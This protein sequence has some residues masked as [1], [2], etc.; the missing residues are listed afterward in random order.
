MYLYR[1]HTERK[2]CVN[3]HQNF[4]IGDMNSPRGAGECCHEVEQN[5]NKIL[6]HKFFKNIMKQLQLWRKITRGGDSQI[7][8][9]H[10]IGINR[11]QEKKTRRK[12]E[13]HFCKDKNGTCREKECC[14]ELITRHTRWK[15][16]NKMKQKF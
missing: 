16:K 7:T 1:I 8:G 14:T 2:I 6:Y 11:H 13:N 5:A 10:E 12:K 15:L 9:G 3:E 4:L